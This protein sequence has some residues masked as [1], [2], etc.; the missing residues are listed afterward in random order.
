MQTGSWSQQGFGIFE[1]LKKMNNRG[2]VRLEF[3]NR[4]VVTQ[5]KEKYDLLQQSKVT[6]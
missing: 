6:V 5:L 2:L 3:H 1:E 4:I